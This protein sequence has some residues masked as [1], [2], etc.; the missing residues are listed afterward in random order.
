MNIPLPPLAEPSELQ[1]LDL[2]VVAAPVAC[3]EVCSL[4]HRSSEKSSVSLLRFDIARGR[5]HMVYVE[6]V[7]PPN[8]QNPFNQ[9][10]HTAIDVSKVRWSVHLNKVGSSLE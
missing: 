4:R 7:I 9:N 1:G 5:Q 10:L 2:F 6:D 3:W 8:L